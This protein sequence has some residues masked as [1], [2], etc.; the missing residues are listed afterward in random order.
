[1]RKIIV[2]IFA[3]LFSYNLHAQ[4]KW[5]GVGG[6]LGCNDS[7][8]QY[9]Q[10]AYALCPDTVNNLLYVGGEFDLAGDNSTN[11]FAEWNGH[12]W[13]S[14][15]DEWYYDDVDAMIMYHGSLYVGQSGESVVWKYDGSTWTTLPSF[16][17][18]NVR[19]FCIYEDTL[20]AGGGLTL[21]EK[22]NI[23]GIAK[24]D[25]TKWLPVGEG[26]NGIEDP[27]VFT[28]SVYQ[29]KL[30][31]GG[32][33]S[34]KGDLGLDIAAWDGT[35]WTQLGS[36]LKGDAY[37][38]NLIFS[39]EV[40]QNKLYVGGADSV[41]NYFTDGIASW[42]GTNW[43]SL[44]EESGMSINTL[45]S[46]DGY[47]FMG[48]DAGYYGEYIQKF[49]GKNL[50]TVD[51]GVNASVYSLAAFDGSLY[52][53]GEFDTAGSMVPAKGI[54]IWTT[55]TNG[56]DEFAANYGQVICYPN[57]TSFS[58]TFVNSQLPII[59]MQ[60]INVLGQIVVQKN[61]N[62]GLQNQSIDVSELSSGI[63]FYRLTGSNSQIAIGK[64]VKQ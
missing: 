29:N 46:F 8:C 21:G 5:Y 42:D 9:W 16:S 60:V 1:M 10:W 50:T 58:I 59:Q 48:G 19:C 40:F 43:D 56:I 45:K 57:P 53:G 27:I 37:S 3:C 35:T 51:S 25:G 33:F 18:G 61:F 31:A 30:I 54:A 47:L 28:M 26:L 4:G 23:I 38:I 24:W 32:Y 41:N 34:I 12:S 62:N 15:S 22:S 17:N 7:L 39:L 20:Y 52:V 2:L 49:D 13:I 64:F 14:V 44:P 55:D 36:G 11:G 63:Y 6:G